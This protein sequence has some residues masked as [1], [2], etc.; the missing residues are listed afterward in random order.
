MRLR[1]LWPVMVAHAAFDVAAV[2][3]IYLNAETRIRHLFFS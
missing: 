3:M 2:F 1:R